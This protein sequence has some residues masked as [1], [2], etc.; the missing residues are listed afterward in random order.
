MVSRNERP[1]MQPPSYGGRGSVPD[2]DP[3]VRTVEQLQRDI[4]ATREIVEANGKATREVLET[5][6][7]GMDKAIEL[8]QRAADKIP[9]NV[10]DEVAQ[11]R[12]LHEE[13]FGSIATQIAIQFSGIAT[14][15]NERDKRTEQLS[16]ADKTAIAAA[17]QA[18]K[19][20]AGAQ[21][22]SNAA[23]N[24]KMESNFAKLIEQGSALVLEIRRNTD[25][26]LNDLK[27]RLDKGEGKLSVADPAINAQL[28]HLTRA[29]SALTGTGHL[30]Q[31]RDIGMAQSWGYIVGAIG[32]LVGVATLIVLVTKIVT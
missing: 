28:E 21:N 16:L 26:Q 17:L 19:E 7:S 13:K 11:L 3:T 27:S 25:V 10:K 8:L 12:E 9:T 5:R 6:L 29:V 31:G 20:A 30:T 32:M 15:F 4:G 24:T 23:A 22:E 14:Q 1:E 2:P 18:Q